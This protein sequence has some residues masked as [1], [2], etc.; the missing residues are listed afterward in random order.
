MFGQRGGGGGGG[1]KKLHTPILRSSQLLTTPIIK[2]H[3]PIWKCMDVGCIRN[4][5][6]SLLQAVLV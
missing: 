2:R 3:K 5:S 4:L 6:H 1:A